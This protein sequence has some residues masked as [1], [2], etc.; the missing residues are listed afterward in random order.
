[1]SV[2]GASLFVKVPDCTVGMY[3]LRSSQGTDAD[4]GFAPKQLGKARIDLG[5]PGTEGEG[6]EYS[7]KTMQESE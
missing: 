4:N 3:L 2:P 5:T 1:M 6:D 7:G